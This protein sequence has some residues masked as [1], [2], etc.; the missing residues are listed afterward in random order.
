MD[1]RPPPN[2]NRLPI[3]I[4]VGVAAVAGY[5]LY[6]AGGNTTVAKKEVEREW[7]VHELS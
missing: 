5:Y 1:S 3:Y 4:G 2:K 7:D 6:T